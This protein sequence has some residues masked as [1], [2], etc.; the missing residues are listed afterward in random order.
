MH[1]LLALFPLFPGSN[2]CARAAPSTRVIRSQ[3]TGALG[4]EPSPWRR[5]YSPVTCVTRCPSLPPSFLTSPAAR[6]RGHTPG[7]QPQ[8][9]Q[10][11][12][13]GAER[14]RGE[15]EPRAR[16]L[17]QRPTRGGGS[18]GG[19]QAR[20]GHEQEEQQRRR[21][22]RPSARP[23]PASSTGQ[24]GDARA[25]RNSAAG[26]REPLATRCAPRPLGRH[27]AAVHPRAGHRPERA[28]RSLPRGPDSES[29]R[30]RAWA[31]AQ[32]CPFR[33]RHASSPSPR[34]SSPPSLASPLVWSPQ[35]GSSRL[36]LCRV[37]LYIPTPLFPACGLP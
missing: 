32:T 29:P 2:R 23:Q 9:A 21:A 11:V 22:G 12:P 31:A 24:R 25:R 14:G 35:P 5:G 19:G 34:A 15:N 30:E 8:T 1:R 27:G 7:A 20:G 36:A 16:A 33:R 3:D 6:K 26:G 28:R 4:C 13:A 10:R 17:S 18:G 37:R